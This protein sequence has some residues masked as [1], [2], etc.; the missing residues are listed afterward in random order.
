MDTDGKWRYYKQM[1]DEFKKMSELVTRMFWIGILLGFICGFTTMLILDI[2][3]LG[4]MPK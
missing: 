4:F 1:K 2:F 3:R